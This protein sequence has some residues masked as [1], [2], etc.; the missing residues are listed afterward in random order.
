LL[1]GD[2]EALFEPNAV[3]DMVRFPAVWG[4][5]ARQ[6]LDGQSFMSG[7]IGER[8]AAE[9]V[10]IWDDP[11]DPRCLPLAIDYEGLP[12]RRVEVISAGVAHG[13]VYD[14]DT[15][16]EAGTLSTGHAGDPFDDFPPGP[17][18]DHIVMPTGTASTEEMI[19]RM[20][21]GIVITRFHYTHCP[22][23]KRVIATGTTRDGTFH[24]RDGQLVGA[25]NNIRIEMGVLDLLSSL[26]EAGE[27]KLCQDWWAANGMSSTN[28][29]VPAL[30]M[31][32][33]RDCWSPT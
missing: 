11:L 24:V 9:T 28:Y 15:A 27:G 3:A 32:L 18:A 25:L 33:P 16:R 8:V 30:R 26:E 12:S 1:R 7:R 31:R 19:E 13:P 21:E 2:Y 10:S 14:A 29:Y 17:T 20:G 22:D 6:V 5:G 4:F 23:P